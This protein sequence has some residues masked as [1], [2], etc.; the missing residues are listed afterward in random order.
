MFE[1]H[2]WKSTFPIKVRK[3]CFW[4]SRHH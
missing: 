1:K 2:I 3:G 4:S